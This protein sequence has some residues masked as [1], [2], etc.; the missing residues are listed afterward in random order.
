MAYGIACLYVFDR[1]HL[2]LAVLVC[3]HGVLL[4]YYHS[5]VMCQESGTTGSL[6]VD[7][8]TGM[9]LIWVEGSQDTEREREEREKEKLHPNLKKLQPNWK[10]KDW[11]I[12]VLKRE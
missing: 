10:W 4:S 1:T 2:V 5:C 12:L 3:P 6:H 8:K 9:Q 7:L 11:K